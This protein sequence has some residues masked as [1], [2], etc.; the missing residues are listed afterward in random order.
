MPIQA[1][2]PEATR[3]LSSA[4]VLTDPASVVKE[5]LDNALDA[6]AT[7]IEV[8]VCA[9]VL[10]KIEVRDNGHGIATEDL[11]VLGRRGHTS[12]LRKFEDLETV[13]SRSL[14]FR[15][16]AIASATVLGTV[17]LT[18]RTDGQDVAAHVKL[19]A[20]GGIASQS[21][22]SHPIGTTFTI[23]NLFAQIPV[24]KQHFLKEVTKQVAKIRDLLQRYAIARKHVRLKLKVLKTPKFDWNFAPRPSDTIKDVVSQTLGRDVASQ[25]TEITSEALENDTAP[26]KALSAR[27][28]EYVFEACMPI[29]GVEFGKNTKGQYLSIDSRPVSAAQGALK[30]IVV[31]FKVQLA[32]ALPDAYNVK[33]PFLCLNIKCPTSSYDPNVEPAKNDVIFVDEYGMLEAVEK[34]FSNFYY[35]DN[36]AKISKA[37]EKRLAEEVQDVLEIGLERERPVASTAETAP[38]NSFTAINHI[39]PRPA[40]NTTLEGNTPRAPLGSRPVPNDIV[41]NQDDLSDNIGK[42]PDRKSVNNSIIETPIHSRLKATQR[43]AD[44]DD[45]SQSLHLNDGMAEEDEIAEIR[46][47]TNP[48][49]IAREIAPLQPQSTTRNADTGA[50]SP[51]QKPRNVTTGQ[52]SPQLDRPR[53]LRRHI[54]AEQVTP[55]REQLSLQ[56]N[57]EDWMHGVASEAISDV[58]QSVRRPQTMQVDEDE[59]LLDGHEDEQPSRRTLPFV[60]AREVVSNVGMD[61]PPQT[62]ERPKAKRVR[63]NADRPFNKPFK[64]PAMQTPRA[65]IVQSGISSHLATPAKSPSRQRLS[66]GTTA[67]RGMTEENDLNYRP[68]AAATQQISDVAEQTTDQAPVKTAIPDGDPRAYLIRRQKSGNGLPSGL[69]KLKRAKTQLLPLE[70]VPEK[71][72]I[73]NLEQRIATNSENIARQ[74]QAVA[75]LDTYVYRG[76]KSLTYDMTAMGM[77]DLTERVEN[78]VTIWNDNEECRYEIEYDF[79]SVVDARKSSTTL[80]REQEISVQ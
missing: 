51:V 18:T 53:S 54:S 20:N 23:V 38:S 14:G 28:P 34:F 68:R 21:P 29:P 55:R 10:D 46:R 2:P 65:T 26:P 74:Q 57:L 49:T 64:V 13:G 22:A 40:Y 1:L 24:R 15:G 44:R 25:C 77:K 19:N 12:K 59:M 78:L 58:I 75:R 6:Q 3:L 61:T 45:E 71:S 5:L 8:L 31:A 62:Q 80:E 52:V 43:I 70:T 63:G 67:L 27:K 42:R 48:W 7:S 76:E 60:T 16:E 41:E 32:R 73:H 37:N 17:S 79:R 69:G 66:A 11:S 47:S 50:I 35:A 56:S 9:N 39:N 4:Q 72:K 30:K 36:M 33:D